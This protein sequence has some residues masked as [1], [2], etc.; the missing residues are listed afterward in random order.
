MSRPQAVAGDLHAFTILPHGNDFFRICLQ[1]YSRH[2]VV[3]VRAF[4]QGF[5][6]DFFSFF[7]V[8]R[9]IDKLLG[10]TVDL[11]TLKVHDAFAQGFVRR[12]LVCSFQRGVNV[13]ATRV[14]LVA[15]LVKYQLAHGFSNKFSMNTARIRARFNNQLLSFGG[16]GLLARDKAVVLHPFNDVQLACPGPLWV[17]DRIKGRGRFRQASQHGSLSN[18]DVF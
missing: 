10:S 18:A 9:Q 1:H 17:D 5:V 13:Q 16:L 7:G 3:V 4:G 2:H 11:A 6:N 15:V 8:F 12:G 14:S